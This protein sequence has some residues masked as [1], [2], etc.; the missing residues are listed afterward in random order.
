LCGGGRS[1]WDGP[2]IRRGGR[3]GAESL[4]G[5]QMRRKRRRVGGYGGGL[6]GW[7]LSSLGC[8]WQADWGL[9]E[10][11]GL[12]VG[13]LGEGSMSY[14]GGYLYWGGDTEEGYSSEWR[15]SHR[16]TSMQILRAFWGE[17]E[18]RQGLPAHTAAISRRVQ[19]S[20]ESV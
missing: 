8:G 2:Q 12:L 5:E 6:M 1:G 14:I 13:G 3:R 11:E 19:K 15:K 9:W 18:M 17:G 16:M 10:E 20:L 7:R 4:S